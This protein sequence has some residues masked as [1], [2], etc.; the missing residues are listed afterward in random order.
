MQ[1]CLC[2]ILQVAAFLLTNPV[3]SLSCM[4]S[5]QQWGLAFD[6]RMPALGARR[7]PEAAL[8]RMAAEMSPL[9]VF[10]GQDLSHQGETADH[11]FVLAEGAPRPC[12]QPVLKPE[13]PRSSA[14]AGGQACPLCVASGER[15]S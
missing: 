14:R 2:H 15:P 5:L 4:G 8:Q 6:N 9:T 1:N 7:L 11:I 12:R 13:R 10:P 3:T